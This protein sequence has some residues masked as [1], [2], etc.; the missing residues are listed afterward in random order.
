MPVELTP[1]ETRLLLEKDLAILVSKKSNLLPRKESATEIA[2]Y[3]QKL[4]QRLSQQEDALKDEKLKESE[5]NIDKI[6][7]GKRKKLLKQG[8]KE[9][10]KRLIIINL[11]LG[12]IFLNV[13]NRQ[14]LI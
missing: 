5:R 4:E 7:A 14:K 1:W 13:R 3:Q 10:G 6:V 2:D 12:N 9:E 8:A 11:I